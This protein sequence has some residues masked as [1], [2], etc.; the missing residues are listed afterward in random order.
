MLRA[1]F[2]TLIFSAG[3]LPG[4]AAANTPPIADAGADQTIL[5]GEIAILNGTGSDPD[6]APVVGYQ[7][8]VC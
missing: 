7:W 1:L 6:G 3:L 5:R 8:A 4:L 2:F